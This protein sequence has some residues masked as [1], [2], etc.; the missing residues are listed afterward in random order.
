MTDLWYAVRALR[1]SPAFAMVAIGTLALGIAG[2]TAV[3]SIVSTVLLTPLPFPDPDRLVFAGT[4]HPKRANPEPATGISI[5]RYRIWRE[6][7]DAF[8][9][10]AGYTFGIA[11]N[12][13]NGNRDEQ[14]SIG[15]STASFFQLF[16]VSA[17]QGRTFTDAEDQPHGPH[18]ALLT[19]GFAMR[20]FGGASNAVGRR[21]TLAGE[22]Y[23][24]IGVLP[25]SFSTRP[26]NPT[27][28]VVPPPDLWL[29]LQLDLSDRGDDNFIVAVGRLRHGVTL[30]E[31]R[32]QTRRAATVFNREFPD[33]YPRGGSL[34]VAPMERL[35][36]GGARSSLWLL[37]AS[38]G[39][40]LVITWVNIACLLLMRGS[41]RHREL[42]IRAATG[43]SRARLIRQLIT[44]TLALAGAGGALG[45]L[46]GV[47]GVRALLTLQPGNIPR[48]E[49]D[50]SNL[51]IDWRV[52]TFAIATT[53]AAG[54]G[55]G[56]LPAWRVSRVDLETSLR[57]GGARSGPG[58]RHER[59]RTLLM[60]AEVALAALLLVS[61]MLVIRS[62]IALRQVD[63]GFNPDR[64]L[65]LTTLVS[66]PP[67]AQTARTAQ[68][69]DAGEAAVR[70]VPGVEQVMAT[71]NGYP[72]QGG[73]ALKVEIADQPPDSDRS[74]VGAWNVVS[75]A[76]FQT[77]RIPLIRGR[78][79]SARDDA[80]AM[81]AVI[82]NQI[83]AKRL[84]PSGE[85]LGDR[86]LLGRGAGPDFADVP[87][88]VVGI[89]GDVR[90]WGLD[91]ELPPIVYVPIAQLPDNEMA[92]LN[93]LGPRLT[94]MV[95]THAADPYRAAVAIGDALQRATGTPV[96][97]VRSMD[98]VSESTILRPRFEAWLMTLFG[99]AALLLAALGV[100]GVVAYA[101][102][103]RT[104]EIGIRVALGA[105][106][107][108]IRGL[109]LA[110]GL[111]PTLIGV[112]LGLAAAWATTRW[113]QAMLFGIPSR[114]AL[115]F[116]I[117]PCAL[118]LVSLAAVWIP[119]RRAVRVDPVI[120][121]RSE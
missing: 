88:H 67:F 29:P 30:E 96:A 13:A 48:L 45:L 83:L 23:L 12:F 85:P 109:V 39:G 119:A 56:L 116:A 61:T 115:S 71:L 2:S 108:E 31:A 114:D 80:H 35:I 54:L 6:Q 70:A 87:R 113:L 92:L 40:V 18:V 93:R 91:R 100:Y 117:V 79:F 101:V 65:T 86:I 11:N 50:A 112:T 64:V 66:E 78:L 57:T 106:P 95:R 20:E 41:S 53:L 10:T 22:S 63:P 28:R 44:E 110:R 102:Q 89:V 121:L 36:V 27:T 19:D 76:Y 69:V 46:L 7:T 3:F 49:A 37:M 107:C 52:F 21:V 47:V 5:A 60:I 34:D 90:N 120:A 73:G 105:T 97:D 55:A 26:L 118:G 62:F 16:G 17:A 74:L 24:V 9:V 103:E 14:V 15:R 75:P 8:Q 38:V 111:P 33:A 58:A 68:L 98:H 25:A 104:R 42:A 99:S 94:W 43:A 81:P 77:L 72:L 59:A 4:T 32:A 1:R 84:W 82:V 51:A